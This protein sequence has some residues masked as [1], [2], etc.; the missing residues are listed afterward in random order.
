MTY[1]KQQT[2][3]ARAHKLLAFFAFNLIVLSG[4]AAGPEDMIDPEIVIR[5][6]LG[7]ESVQGNVVF[8]IETR[9][10]FDG[11]ITLS[12]GDTM[13]HQWSPG[14]TL[15]LSVDT[16]TLPDD[17]YSF[18]AEGTSQD[19]DPVT[20]S[21]ALTVDNNG[22]ALMLVEPILPDIYLEDGEVSVVVSAQDIVGVARVNFYVDDV[23]EHEWISPT[24]TTLTTTYDPASLPEGTREIFMRVEAT[25]REGRTS[26]TGRSFNIL[27]R[28]LF[29]NFIDAAEFGPVILPDQSIVVGTDDRLSVFEEDGTP[30]CN[31]RT[32]SGRTSAP[33]LVLREE[34]V[35]YWSTVTALHVVNLIDCVVVASPVMDS[36]VVTGMARQ[37][38]T[39]VSVDFNGL[40]RFHEAST[41][42]VVSEFDLTTL[43]M[44]GILEM[45][46]SGVAFAPD[47][48]LYLAG[49]IGTTSGAL[50]VQAAMGEMVFHPVAEAI[51][52]GIVALADGVLLP[53]KEGNL[54]RYDATGVSAW[55]R[56]AELSL[57][58][59]IESTPVVWNDRIIIG[60]GASLVHGLDLAT[61]DTVWTH[62]VG[63]DTT[64]S[65]AGVGTDGAQRF[66]AVGDVLGGVT[67]LD[68]EGALHFQSFVSLGGDS[69]AVKGIPAV[70]TE[71]VAVID[72]FGLLVVYSL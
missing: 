45:V 69:T 44:P 56:P 13:L 61:G 67:V 50:F 39:V 14:G 31:V 52:G 51:E 70:G 72:E 38:S 8:E 7:T 9:G 46:Y 59:V 27:R 4:C 33:L 5:S 32:P 12:V 64:I 18:L 43:A 6:P 40:V 26:E 25:D 36:I 17:F 63:A 22:P 47:G 58:R 41:G 35:V 57:G 60:D 53:G 65:R 37:S 30:R 54:Y 10:R 55:R 20:D 23:L 2:T 71:R 49:T 15:S 19:G 42:A 29:T 34:N 3:K 62:D 11:D 66:F 68:R 28:E 24:S 21:V 16:S 48:T 1:A